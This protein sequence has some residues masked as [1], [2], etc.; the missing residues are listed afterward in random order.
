VRDIVLNP[1]YDAVFPEEPVE[2]WST[3]QPWN[4]L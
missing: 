2:I 3:E 1:T 4:R